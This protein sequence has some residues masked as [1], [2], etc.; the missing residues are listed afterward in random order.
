MSPSDTLLIEEE[1]VDVDGA[2]RDGAKWEGGVAESNYCDLNCT[3][4]CLT[5]AASMAR[6]IEKWLEEGK[7]TE[8]WHK[9][10]VI[11]EGKMSLLRVAVS[12]KHIY[13][14]KNKMWRKIYSEMLKKRKQKSSTRLYDRVIV[15]EWVQNKVITMFMNLG[16]LAKALHGV[17]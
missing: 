14:R 16:H 10:H 11:I 4:L 5:V 15:R 12:S 1:G 2:E 13:N 8:K 7:G 9:I 17:N 3:S 6:M